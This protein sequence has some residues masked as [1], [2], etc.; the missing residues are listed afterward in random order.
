VV[1]LCYHGIS[2]DWP[3][4]IAIAPN[5]LERQVES[6]LARGYRSATFAEAVVAREPG[7]LVVVTFD[8]GYESVFLLARPLLAR[9]GVRATVFVP[10][11]HVEREKP[12]GWPG[13]DF[14]ADTPWADELRLARWDQLRTLAGEGWEIGSHTRTHPRLP[15]LDD[16]SLMRELRDSRTE[17]EDRLGVSCVSVAYPYGD[18]SPRVAAAAARAGY[19]AGGG[20]LP[21]R[22]SPRNP[23]LYPRVFVGRDHDDATVRRRSRRSVRALQASPAWPRIARRVGRPQRTQPPVVWPAPHGGAS[24]WAK[25]ARASCSSE[26]SERERAMA[27]LALDSAAV[28]WEALVAVQRRPGILSWFAFAP[29]AE[30]PHA[31]VV[32]G[33]GAH[34]RRLQDG[35]ARLARFRAILGGS[36]AAR[37]LPPQEL[38]SGLVEDGWAVVEPA[39]GPVSEGP[40]RER[41]MGWLES[42]QG[43]TGCGSE[44]WASRLDA[45]RELVARAW[46]AHMTEA[47]EPVLREHDRLARELRELPVSVCAEHGGFAPP[48]VGLDPARALVVGGWERSVERGH[49][50]ADRWAYELEPLGARA[51]QRHE[52]AVEPLAVARRRF[53]DDLAAAGIDRRFAGVTLL[54]ALAR[55]IVADGMELAPASVRRAKIGLM[56]AGTQLALGT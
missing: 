50:F 54:P 14:W 1:V 13:T 20:L 16:A 21:D 4:Q 48:D 15:E 30:S 47:L 29:G 8:D 9:L 51:A 6:F 40:P 55:G 42:F 31:V 11:D 33:G 23:L 7:R 27:A 18:T 49:P 25:R 52:W 12:V 53:A 34:G 45:E 46:S 44:P 56:A 3:T 22:L 26:P 17:L 32:A 35:Q 19:R 39:W 36:D 10:T 43:I 38:W 2:S 41:A 5:D 37:A 28:T 24:A